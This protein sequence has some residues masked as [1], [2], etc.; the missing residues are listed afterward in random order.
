MSVICGKCGNIIFVSNHEDWKTNVN[1]PEMT[2]EKCHPKP[3]V[4]VDSFRCKWCG[5]QGVSRMI[6]EKI[7]ITIDLQTELQN[8]VS[9]SL[10]NIPVLTSK[11]LK[12]A[13]EELEVNDDN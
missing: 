7:E 6:K 5:R 4:P 1:R 9:K 11:E 12:K 2:C 8:C 10:K 13:V 3:S